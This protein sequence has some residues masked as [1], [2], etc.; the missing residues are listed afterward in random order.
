MSIIQDKCDRIT[1]KEKCCG[2]VACAMCELT[3]SSLSMLL[4]KEAVTEDHVG[5]QVYQIENAVTD[6]A[7]RMAGFRFPFFQNEKLPAFT[8]TPTSGSRYI[9]PT[10]SP[11]RFLY[12]ENV[13]FQ[14]MSKNS[15][16]LL[17]IGS[18]PRC[19]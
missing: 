11:A 8:R 16:I 2:G 5:R 12:R 10:E 1:T 13:S 6:L 18:F 19:Q 15:C 17:D 9:K 4:Q 3:S 14:Q 7:F